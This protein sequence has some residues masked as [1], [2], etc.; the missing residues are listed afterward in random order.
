M[1]CPRGDAFLAVALL[2]AM[3]AG[4]ALEVAPDA[5][6][7]GKLLAGI[8]RLQDI[9]H[10]WNPV[11]KKVAVRAS[12]AA[13]SPSNH[14]TAS[15]FSGGVDGT[16]TALKHAEIT[17]LVLINGFDL[18]L[19]PAA[20]AE[21]V[22]RN[23]RFA[24]GL[25]KTLLPVETNF[26]D[27]NDRFGVS[28]AL[29]HT[30]CLGSVA[31]ALA[32]P[33]TYIASSR[34]YRHLIPA[35]SDPLTDPLWSSEATEIIHDGAEASR[36]EKTRKIF[37]CRAVPGNVRVCWHDPNR[38][39]GRCEKRLRTRMI[40]RALGVSSPAFE[41]LVP[42][43]NSRRFARPA[44]ESWRGSRTACGLRNGPRTGSWSGYC[45]APFAAMS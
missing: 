2:P 29:S 31:L 32:F 23:R 20:F 6:S 16:Y 8:D 39:C 4:E 40:L 27:F 42:W 30:S 28:R 1:I 34:T 13:P 43:M 10:C 25:G 9:Y 38:N 17:H 41:E 35:G 44:S 36:R 18:F 12:V 3:P 24:E 26:L 33:R 15:F 45:D 7:S 5:P 21:A 37:E 22:E 14:G 19:E 11:F